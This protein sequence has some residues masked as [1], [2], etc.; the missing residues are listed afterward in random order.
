[1]PSTALLWIVIPLVV[2]LSQPVL[3][4]MNVR[5]AESTGHVEA[6]VLLHVIGAGAGIGFVMA[7]LRGAGGWAGLAQ[8]PWWAWTAGIVGVAG[9][10]AMNR[11]IPELG[12]ATVLA[13]TVAAQFSAALLFEH[14]GL[15][16]AKVHAATLT[17]WLGAAFLVAGAWLVSR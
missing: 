5:V 13:L 12:V 3:W 15:M 6:A 17:R 11:A 14:Y 16:G 10:A 2:G 4:Q 8:V 1:M 7:G 9:M